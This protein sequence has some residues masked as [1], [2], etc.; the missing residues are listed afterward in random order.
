MPG[1]APRRTLK[2]CGVYARSSRFAFES[3][4]LKVSHQ[5]HSD[6]IAGRKM[7]EYT[8]YNLQRLEAASYSLHCML[9][10]RSFLLQPILAILFCWSGSFLSSGEATTSPSADVII[11]KAVERASNTRLST[12]RPGY[13]YTKVNITEELDGKGKVKQRKERVFQVYFRAGETCVKLLEVNGH[14]PAQADMKF[15]AETQSNVHQFLGQ[16]AS[17]GDNRENF[18]TPELAARFD[19]TLVGQCLVNG[20]ATYQITFLPKSPEPPIRKILDRLLNHISGTLWIDAEEYEIAR[21]D[22]QL[23]SEVDFLGGLIGCLHKLAYSMTR[24]RVADGIWLHSVSCGDFEG[25]KLLDPMRIKMKSEST[26][27]RLMA[28][29]KS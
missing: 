7:P 14:P 15:Q 21:A 29:N 9:V 22:L 23:G 13:T 17:G 28:A 10:S 11:Q 19:Y 20:R 24:V 12:S 27:F 5:R 3:G 25:R 16:P 6:A 26:N 4:A 18:L 8:E 1:P 2:E